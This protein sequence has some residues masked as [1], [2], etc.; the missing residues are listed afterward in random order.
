[1]TRFPEHHM[2]DLPMVASAPFD[3]LRA[4]RSALLAFFRSALR[5]RQLRKRRHDKY[6]PRRTEPKCQ[7]AMPH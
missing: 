1:M 4:A 5:R 7:E 2:R 3:I 6:R